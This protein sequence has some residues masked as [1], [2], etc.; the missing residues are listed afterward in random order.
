MNL[1]VAAS[2]YGMYLPNKVFDWEQTL[3]SFENPPQGTMPET[4]LIYPAS[5][6]PFN[7]RVIIPYFLAQKSDLTFRVFDL[8][9]RELLEINRF[10]VAPGI[11][12]WDWNA[13]GFVSGTYIM[14]IGKASRRVILLK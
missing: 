6:N 8:A 9:G 4:C 5:P 7:S 13:V 1:A 10:G 3:A 12:Q 2:I 11:H 14:R